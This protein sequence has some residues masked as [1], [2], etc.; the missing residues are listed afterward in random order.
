MY[1]APDSNSN[2]IL[3]Y[4]KWVI[5]D[6]MGGYKSKI[7]NEVYT[8][9]DKCPFEMDQWVYEWEYNWFTDDTLAITC[10]N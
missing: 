8:D 3:Y 6:K 9:M 7:M 1:L 5:G 2:P 4:V 10:T